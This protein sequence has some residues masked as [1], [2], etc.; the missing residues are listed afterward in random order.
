MSNGF[1]H[2]NLLRGVV[3]D[4]LQA[5]AR[6]DDGP[7]ALWAAVEQA[8]WHEV[9]V[10]EA[11][12]GDEELVDL[13]AIVQGLGRHGV[14]VPLLERHLGTWLTRGRCTGGGCVVLLPR[15]GIDDVEVTRTGGSIRVSGAVGRAPWLPTCD[16]LLL[17]LDAETG[18]DAQA[19][20]IEI[21]TAAVEVRSGSNLAGEPRHS[22]VLRNSPA[23]AMDVDVE[24]I[25]LLRCRAAALNAAMMLGA[26]ERVLELTCDHATSRA[27][28]GKPLA[29]FQMVSASIALISAGLAGA[30]A[31]VD[32]AIEANVSRHDPVVTTA[33]A[34][35]WL[36]RA[37]TDTARMAHQVH[38]A[39]GLTQEYELGRFT[40]R[41]LAWRDEWGT[42]RYWATALAK[43]FS[44]MPSGSS[45][46]Q[47][48]AAT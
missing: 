15:P 12:T 10:A 38:G 7:A 28:F 29:A 44:G 22:V 34:K 8:G 17:V 18:T 26:L 16:S 19:L 21:G 35:I 33:A 39:M 37:A 48:I 43:R 20:R 47:L 24:R 46:Q 3:D 4:V 31:A 14:S 6:K 40:P 36:G 23:I 5:A 42:A 32:G 27:Q 25:E 30:R 45:W 9:A 11:G 1:D 13:A 41:L 2:S